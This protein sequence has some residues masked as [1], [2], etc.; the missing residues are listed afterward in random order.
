MAMAGGGD[1]HIAAFS[2][3]NIAAES[4]MLLIG[5]ILFK[6]APIKTS[7]DGVGGCLA[8]MANGLVRKPSLKLA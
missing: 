3:F 8:S 5:T 7:V 4:Q 1:V 6:K 2:R